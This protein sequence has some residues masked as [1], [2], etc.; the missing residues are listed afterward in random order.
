MDNDSTM[1]VTSVYPDMRL[2][3][4]E[5]LNPPLPEKEI[6]GSNQDPLPTS[7][8]VAFIGIN[9]VPD[10]ADSQMSSHRLPLH[11]TPWESAALQSVDG[12]AVTKHPSVPPKPF[13]TFACCSVAC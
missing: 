2:G 13:V 5:A 3:D 8:S 12:N 6:V 1:D 10:S 4:S 9:Y 7:S 11:P